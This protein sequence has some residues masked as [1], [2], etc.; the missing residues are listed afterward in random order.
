MAVGGHYLA[1]RARHSALAHVRAFGDFV[2][3]DVLPSILNLEKRAKEV[4]EEEYARLGSQPADE[5]CSYDMA[6]AAEDAN[7]KGLAFYQTMVGVR[8][9]VLNLFTA[10]LFH[11][12]EQELAGLCSDGSMCVQPP[13]DSNLKRIAD[14]YGQHFWLDLRSLSSWGTIEELGLVANAVR[15]AEGRSAEKVRLLRPELFQDP[16]LGEPLPGWEAASQPLRLPLGGEGLYITQE[17]FQQYS[18][19][20]ERFVTEIVNHF[21]DHERGL[22]PRS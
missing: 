19:A 11:L 17:H 20:A 6:D 3:H 8:Q 9:A 22:Y 15:H 4:A 12:V 18:Q 2:L 21:E 14:W 13:A 16:I 7:E 10:G 1:M 5:Y